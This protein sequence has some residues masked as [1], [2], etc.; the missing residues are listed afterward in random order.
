MFGASIINRNLYSISKNVLNDQIHSF[1][2]GIEQL[3][4]NGTFNLNWRMTAN[5]EIHNNELDLSLFF[6]IGPHEMSRCMMPHD[7]HNYYF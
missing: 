2:L 6:D 7:Q 1:P 5:P 3:D 4:K